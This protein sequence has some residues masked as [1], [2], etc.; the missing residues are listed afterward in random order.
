VIGCTRQCYLLKGRS[1]KKARRR[2]GFATSKYRDGSTAPLAD[3]DVATSAQYFEGWPD[4]G[5]HDRRETFQVKPRDAA[6]IA[7]A[8]TGAGLLAGLGVLFFGTSDQI[9]RIPP[10]GLLV[11]AVATL[12]GM[13]YLQASR[14]RT[15]TPHKWGSTLSTIGFAILVVIAALLIGFFLTYH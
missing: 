5:E 12:A 2:C 14:G 13:I 8:I 15:T 4:G 3:A 11:A 1:L 7:T 10:S 6:I 9:D